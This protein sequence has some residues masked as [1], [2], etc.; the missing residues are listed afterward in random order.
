M[1]RDALEGSYLEGRLGCVLD[2]LV[3]LP[4]RDT[5]V[6]GAL[7]ATSQLRHF[8]VS[9]FMSADGVGFAVTDA[10]GSFNVHATFNAQGS[11][12]AVMKKIM[13]GLRNQFREEIDTH[14]VTSAHFDQNGNIWLQYSNAGY[15][16]YNPQGLVGLSQIAGK[17]K[18]YKE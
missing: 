15:M 7:S 14:N 2:V 4:Q 10:G 12:P 13:T 17:F 18:L 3:H 1:E 11:T 9:G 6:L 5:D 8:S 16:I